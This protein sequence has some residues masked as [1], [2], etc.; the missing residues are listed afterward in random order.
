[1][2]D[3]APGCAETIVLRYNFS[4][5]Q[6]KSRGGEGVLTTYSVV[7]RRDCW[8]HVGKDRIIPKNNGFP[9]VKL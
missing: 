7:A 3:N 1:M 2:I 4:V 6:S 8:K 5:E 9:V